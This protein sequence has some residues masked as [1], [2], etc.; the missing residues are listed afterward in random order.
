MQT[1]QARKPAA[2]ILAGGQGSRMGGADKALLVLEGQSLIARLLE[3]LRPQTSRQ[4]IVANGALERFSG[5]GAE[6]LADAWPGQPSDLVGPLAGIY[7]GLAHVQTGDVLCVPVDAHLLPTELYARLEKARQEA[8]ASI[9]CVHDGADLQPLCCLLPASAAAS[10]LA[11][12]QAGLYSVR[13]W[14]KTQSLATADFS[15]WPRWAWSVN[16]PLEWAQLGN[17]I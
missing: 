9:A 7:T 3:T 1:P 17:A 10:A 13:D 16:T 15:D 14:L 5:L 4:V 6:V 2:L 8:G 11:A 12:L